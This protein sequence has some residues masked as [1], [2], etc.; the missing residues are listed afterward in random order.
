[1]RLA[2]VVCFN[3]ERA[4]MQ[5]F[6][7]AIDKGKIID[8]NFAGGIVEFVAKETGIGAK[9]HVAVLVAF[10]QVQCRKIGMCQVEAQI[11]FRLV[12]SLFHQAVHRRLQIVVVDGHCAIKHVAIEHHIGYDIVVTIALYVDIGHLTVEFSV[13]LFSVDFCLNL[14]VERHIAKHRLVVEHTAQ[15]EFIG[16]QTSAEIEPF[17]KD[18][19]QFAPHFEFAQSGVDVTIEAHIMLVALCSAVDAHITALGD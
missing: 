5:A 19:S 11:H 3:P 18:V 2:L 14:G 4:H 17:T 10:H 1:M 9:R 12:A 15:H 7:V 13:D 16:S 8:D 6:V